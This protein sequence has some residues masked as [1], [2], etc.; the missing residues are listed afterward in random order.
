M[1]DNKQTIELQHGDGTPICTTE[2]HCG[3]ALPPIVRWDDS[4]DGERDFVYTSGRVYREQ[5]AYLLSLGEVIPRKTS[6][7]DSDSR[8]GT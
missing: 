7:L 1:S 6:L 8:E 2:I 4:P 3:G 5:P